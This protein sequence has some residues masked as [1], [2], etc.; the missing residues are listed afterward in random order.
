MK[1]F[2]E[3]VSGD[4][5][6]FVESTDEYWF[7]ITDP[8]DFNGRFIDDI[9]DYELLSFD[10]LDEL[11]K[12]IFPK[13]LSTEDDLDGYTLGIGYYVCR[14]LERNYLGKFFKTKTDIGFQ[15]TH[16]EL[17]QPLIFYPYQWV[18]NRLT[19]RKRILR[20]W[21]AEIRPIKPRRI[22]YSLWLVDKK[23]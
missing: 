13:K 8:I 15:I 5:L 10:E 11:I 21:K 6:K 7:R 20:Q 22:D 18:Y 14:T 19:S 4:L 2:G 23:W 17:K 3:K 16:P 12:E 9:L 1:F